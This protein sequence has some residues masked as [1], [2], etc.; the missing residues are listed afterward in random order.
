MDQLSFTDYDDDHPILK[1]DAGHNDTMITEKYE[2][3]VEM[4]IQNRTTEL[5]WVLLK[6]EGEVNEWALKK[7]IWDYISHEAWVGD[8][9]YTLQELLNKIA[10]FW[11]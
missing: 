4:K 10:T 8:A 1:S 11:A 9:I 2:P 5:W 3:E 7:F 6:S